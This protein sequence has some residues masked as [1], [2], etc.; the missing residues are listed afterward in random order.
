VTQKESR[1]IAYLDWHLPHLP[2]LSA[3]LKPHGIKTAI[4]A[5]PVMFEDPSALLA[6][7]I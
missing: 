3:R 2:L 1:L 4:R 6:G 7:E 5:L